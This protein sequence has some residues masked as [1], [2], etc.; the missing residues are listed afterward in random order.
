MKQLAT[1]ISLLA[2][3][4]AYAAYTSQHHIEFNSQ[5]SAKDAT[6]PFSQ[7]EPMSTKLLT[8]EP[9]PVQIA[10]VFDG[11]PDGPDEMAPKEAGD[12]DGMPYNPDD[13]TFNLWKKLRDVNEDREPGL[14]NVQRVNGQFNWHGIPTF[15]HCPV[16]LSPA[17][18]KAGQVEVAIMGADMVNDGRAATYGPQEMRNPRSSDFYQVW[19]NWSMPHQQT[20]VNAFDELVIA[21][22]GDAPL[23]LYSMYRSTPVVRKWSPTLQESTLRMVDIQS[24]L[25]LADA[26]H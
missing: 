19:G 4:I 16:A 23:D 7:P 1:S 10:Q 3:A 15:F 2:A 5:A 12:P 11:T 26:M 24:R 18:L 17:D 20:L 9:E 8:E 14:I 22:Y 6:S 25:S 13:P 21:D